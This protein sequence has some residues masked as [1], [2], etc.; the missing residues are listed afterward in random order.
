[1]RQCSPLWHTSGSSAPFSFPN[2]EAGSRPGPV[3]RDHAVRLVR[4]LSKTRHPGTGV[5]QVPAQA[6]YKGLGFVECGRLGAQVVIDGEEDDE[7]V[8][9]FFLAK[10]N[11]GNV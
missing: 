3:R 1:M 5:E 9:E 11:R 7:I 10:W 8:M 2:G 6:F 4:G